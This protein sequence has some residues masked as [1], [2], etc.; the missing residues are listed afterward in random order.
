MARSDYS[1]RLRRLGPEIK[2]AE[3]RIES[4]ELQRLGIEADLQELL[5]HGYPDSPG[6]AISHV[7]R[8]AAYLRNQMGDAWEVL[9]RL[10]FE[11]DVLEGID[12]LL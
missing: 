9:N 6:S 12:K 4:I 5:R 3:R 8:R 7:E 2:G 10:E 11:R 1:Q